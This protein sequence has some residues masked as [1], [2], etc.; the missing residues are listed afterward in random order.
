MTA[1][2]RGLGELVA[3]V[4]YLLG[5]VPARSVVV[6]ATTATGVGPTSR[7]DVPA[8]AADL[9]AVAMTVADQ[10]ERVP[11]ERVDVIGFDDH[12]HV[13]ELV[14][15]IA[16]EMGVPAHE[17]LVADGRWRLQR[18][19][20]GRCDLGPSRPVPTADRVPAVAD[21]VL[22]EIEVYADRAAL[23][24][25]VCPGHPLVTAA[26]RAAE[27]GEVSS[28]RLAAAWAAVVD[29]GDTAPPVAAL[30][31]EVLSIAT[32]SLLDLPLRD[33]LMGWLT[34]DALD[35]PAADPWL[36]TALTRAIGT[37]SW[38]RPD[39]R[40]GVEHD[41]QVVRVTRR[42]QELVTITPEDWVTGTGTLLGYWCWV[43]GNGALAGVALERAAEA[44]PARMAELVL[45]A[46][47]LGVRPQD[48]RSSPREIAL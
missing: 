5:F 21:Q 17:V 24:A 29:A 2:L 28:A 25:S 27:P 44:G 4:P 8:S 39:Q 31:V 10:M 18:C 35:L 48:L 46:M 33:D 43:H 22:R 7:V 23:A 14:A 1:K 6:V 11:L 15:L 16:D 41:V 40:G 9:A 3:Y 13:S 47:S 34:P 19:G 26:V 42:L 12:E 36:R 37:P 30:P 32:R 20:C 45:H 38:R